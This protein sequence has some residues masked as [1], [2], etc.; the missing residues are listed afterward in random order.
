MEP[1]SEILD[2]HH[3]M[4]Q[5]LLLA[6]LSGITLSLI[7]SPVKQILSYWHLTIII[8]RLG[9]AIMK[10]VSIPDGMGGSVYIEYLVLQPKR[11]L[12][13]SIKHYKGNIFAAEKIE[14]WTQVIGHHSYKFPNPLFHMESDL[15]VLRAISPKTDME[16]AVIFEKNCKFPKGKPEGVF[17]YQGLQEM[18]RNSSKDAVPE[19]LN[20]AWKMICNVAEKSSQARKRIFYHRRDMKRFLSGIMFFCITLL[21]LFWYMGWLKVQI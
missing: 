12:L 4:W 7:Y 15:Q 17:E 8:R 9:L 6:V 13:L 5:G 3:P 19:A 1:I 20:V 11:L 14:Q 2:I 18:T 21:Y 16:A 10:E